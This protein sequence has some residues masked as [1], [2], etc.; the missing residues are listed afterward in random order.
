MSHVVRINERFTEE[1]IINH[2]LKVEGGYVDDAADL[3]GETR[4]GITEGLAL[5][6]RHLWAEHD[7]NGMM[8]L[9]PYTLAYSIIREEFYLRYRLDEV[10]T[11]CPPLAS[12]ILDWAVNA[13][14]Y[15]PIRA[16]Q[17]HLNAANNCGEYYDDL[18]DDGIIGSRT[19]IA[20]TAYLDRRGRAGER[21]LMG[22][23]FSKQTVNYQELTV[24][25]ELNE[26]FYC[27]WLD[28]V[29]QEQD[30]MYQ[31]WHEVSA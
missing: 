29:R 26:R 10:I 24:R 3:G 21:W 18:I 27:G 16:L 23:M 1:G 31:Y 9:L 13:G 20:L 5:R 12:K 14:G 7:F 8:R 25:R 30:V 17:L 15:E 2:T 4:F 11:L 6:Y 19:F 28:R 22:F